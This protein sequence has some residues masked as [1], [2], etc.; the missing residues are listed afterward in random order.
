MAP[1]HGAKRADA[2]AT[3]GRARDLRAQAADI[4]ETKLSDANKA[5][6]L[7]QQILAEDPG[8]PQAADGIQRICTRSGDFVSVVN[9]FEALAPLRSAAPSAPRRSPRSAS[10]HQDQIG[11]MTRR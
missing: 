8:H 3:P 2:A 4:L 11:D 10:L 1:S 7:Y 6:D 5:K 9:I